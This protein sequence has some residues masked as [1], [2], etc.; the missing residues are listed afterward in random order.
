MRRVADVLGVTVNDLL[1][2]DDVDPELSLA[3]RAAEQRPELRVL[4][5]LSSKATKE[6]VEAVIKLLNR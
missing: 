6:D 4:F 2:Y 3:L 5:S 1:G